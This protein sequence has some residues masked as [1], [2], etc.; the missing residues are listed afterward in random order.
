MVAGCA[1]AAGLALPAAASAGHG[2]ET[3]DHPAP[4]LTAGELPGD[5][6]IA[7]GEGA[8]W[9]KVK[10]FATGNP[11]TD[12]DFFTQGERMYMSAGT[13][14]IGPNGGG[15]TIIELSDDGE[16]DPKFVAS[17]PSAAC[18]SDPSAALALQHD[19][20]ATPKGNVLFN[21]VNPKAS[22]E[23]AQLL[24]DATDA[25]GRC[26]DQGELGIAGAPQGGI[27]IIDITDPANP[28]EIGFTSHIGEA[29]TVNVD[30]KRPHIAYAVTSDL[31]SA[32]E[33]GTLQNEDPDDSDRFDL[34]GFEIIDL[35]SC[36]DFPAGTSVAD[37]R[38]ACAPETY[39]YRYPSSKIS[40]GHTDQGG[41]YGCH[42][43]EVYPN[44]LLTCGS[45][46]T[47]I[48]FNMAGA[49]DA[50]GTPN[51]YRDDTVRGEPL[52]CSRR[53]TTSVG[54]FG[55]AAMIMDCVDGT[56]EG[57]DDLTV[58]RWLADGAPSVRGV[59]VL[60]VAYHQGR[61]A[62]GAVDP[63]FDSTEDIDF[64]HETELTGS[65]K[66]LLATDE[67]GGGVVPPGAACSPVADIRAGNGGIHA[68]RVDGL[69]R[70]RPESA[71]Q[72]F[73]AYAT[74]PDGEKAIY[75]APIR[76][77]HPQA[78]FCTA[79]VFHQIPGQNRIFMGWYSQ[80]TQVVDFTEHDD[81]TI[82][83]S[84]AG[85]FIP[86]SA[87]TWVSA[88]FD[89]EANHDGTYTY[90]GA[91][92]DTLLGQGRAAVDIYKV[93]LPAPPGPALGP[94]ERP[95]SGTPGRDRL[96]GEG[97]GDAIKGGSGADRIDG[98]GGEDC[99]AGGRGPD[100]IR[101]GAG[102]DVIRGGKGRDR[103]W[104]GAGDDRIH[105]AGGGRDRVDCGKG[106]D[107]VIADRRDRI[108]ANCE[109][110]RIRR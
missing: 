39:R 78:S 88:V 48:L 4:N 29:H 28:V 50:Q 20:E 75:R 9:E 104:A 65:G 40:L 66:F 108:A 42:E 67:R 14:A 12:L 43:L 89:Y 19:V 80:G 13:L 3:L 17:H 79:H 98:G 87:N 101:G 10:T 30:P 16:I 27:E 31:V 33:D 21:G 36:M 1:L 107:V 38:Q 59:K 34:D 8:E 95:I 54:P 103:I 6:L 35:S 45:G 49:F 86:E 84:E 26:H 61:G 41:A 58:A 7:G 56:G 22:R 63:A 11:L 32:N 53:A 96:I 97:S 15:Q 73:E 37:K 69:Q 47:G 93:T 51:D 85:Y 99:I 46:S 23:D 94:C 90:W 76:T 102:D 71:E 74:D 44:D 83:F 77:P 64:N 110:V 82:E 18:L 72:A 57:D 105:V 60:G 106:R 62:G 100:R 68:Y 81:G 91:T 70:K 92:A 52:P 5:A 24:L 109:R 25:P 55:T 2:L